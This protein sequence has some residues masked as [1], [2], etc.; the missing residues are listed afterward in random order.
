M[1][2]TFRWSL[3]SCVSV[4]I[5]QANVIVLGILWNT[6]THHGTYLISLSEWWLVYAH[7]YTRCDSFLYNLCS[8]LRLMYVYGYIVHDGMLRSVD[9]SFTDVSGQIVC[10][11]FSPR[12]LLDPWKWDILE[13]RGY[14]LHHARSVQSRRYGNLRLK[15]VG[16]CMAFE[17][18]WCDWCKVS[19]SYAVYKRYMWRVWGRGEMHTGL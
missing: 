14:H 6:N 10:P 19:V 5:S 4:S 8:I 7:L 18:V 3:A 15:N 12:W 13:E 17:I 11:I 1:K 2:N 16:I 9:W